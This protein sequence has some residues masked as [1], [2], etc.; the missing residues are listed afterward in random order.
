MS[1]VNLYCGK[2][3]EKRTRKFPEWKG[4]LHGRDAENAEK[5]LRRGGRKEPMVARGAHASD[6]EVKAIVEYLPKAFGR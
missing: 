1:D 3:P 2:T 4:V 5:A 6:A